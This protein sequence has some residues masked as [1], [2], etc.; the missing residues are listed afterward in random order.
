VY[1]LDFLNICGILDP[2][3]GLKALN[4]DAHFSAALGVAASVLVPS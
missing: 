1:P 2:A 3:V 4:N